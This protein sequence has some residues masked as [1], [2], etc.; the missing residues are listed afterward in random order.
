MVFGFSPERCSASLRKQR[1]PSPESAVNLAETPFGFLNTVQPACLACFVLPGYRLANSFPHA[2]LHSPVSEPRLDGFSARQCFFIALPALRL[3]KP[4]PL[5]IAGAF[6]IGPEAQILA[7]AVFNLRSSWPVGSSTLRF[8]AQ[9]VHQS[10]E[11][12]N[13]GDRSLPKIQTPVVGDSALFA[14]KLRTD[15]IAP[16]GTDGAIRGIGGRC[17]R[18]SRTAA[19]VSRNAPIVLWATLTLGSSSRTGS[20]RNTIESQRPRARLARRGALE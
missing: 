3:Q 7:P 15:P 5:E 19:N 4:V 12:A 16:N 6:E 8:T 20:R 9:D 11:I 13:E 2:C 10:S 14:G 17:E 1:S 18:R